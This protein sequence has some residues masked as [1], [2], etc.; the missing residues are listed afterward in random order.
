[1]RPGDLVR[2]LWERMEARDWEGVRATL[3]DDFVCDWR[4]TFRD[5]PSSE[6]HS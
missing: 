3:A 2:A 1:M 5:P 6:E 4:A